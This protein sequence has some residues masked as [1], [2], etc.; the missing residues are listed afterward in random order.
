[1]L[2]RS[3]PGSVGEEVAFHMAHRLFSSTLCTCRTC[4]VRKYGTDIAPVKG[5]ESNHKREINGHCCL[6]LPALPHLQKASLYR[7]FFFSTHC[8][9]ISYLGYCNRILVGKQQS[10]RLVFF[11]L[12][13]KG[14]HVCLDALKV[15]PWSKV[16]VSGQQCDTQHPS[17]FQDRC[18]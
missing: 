5:K 15:V 1:M 4:V 18:S 7:C 13:G 17:R 12:G 3:D 11:F 2:D 14:S 9:I 6:L 8:F 16:R 10:K